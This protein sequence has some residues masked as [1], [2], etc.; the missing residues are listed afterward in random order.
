[1]TSAS[2]FY[3]STRLAPADPPKL[4]APTLCE[5]TSPP[6]PSVFL[7][8]NRDPVRS[9]C[10]V[11]KKRGT[12]IGR[13]D[14]ACVPFPRSRCKQLPRLDVEGCS[15]LRD[16]IERWACCRLEHSEHLRTRHAGKISESGQRDSL[17]LRRQ[18]N[19]SRDECSQFARLHDPDGR[20]TPASRNPVSWTLLRC[21]PSAQDGKGQSCANKSRSSRSPRCS[22]LRRSCS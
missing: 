11:R 20:E 6:W 4:C 5:T 8:G 17:A 21:T 3:G 12:P 19:I 7:A 10:A 13:R 15:D 1:M 18:A 16:P 14:S 22:S 2:P 9:P